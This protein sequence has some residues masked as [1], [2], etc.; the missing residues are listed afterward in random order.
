MLSGAG[1]PDLPEWLHPVLA[2]ATARDPADR[3]PSANEFR[4]ALIEPRGSNEPRPARD[5]R[6]RLAWMAA[7]GAAVALVGAAVAFLPRSTASADPMRVVVAGFENRTGDSALATIG[8][9]ASDYVARG[10][11]VTRLLHGVYDTRSSAMEAGQPL[12]IGAAAGRDL[13]SR[14][15]AGTVLWGSYYREGDSLHFEAQLIEAPTGK[16]LLSLEPAVGRVEERTRVVETL[17]QRVMAAFAVISG[18]EF[19]PWTAASVPPTYD[20]YREMLAGA[21]AAGEYDFGGAVEHYRRAAALDS[22]FSGAQSAAALWLAYGR[23]CAT[24]DSIA[25]RLEQRERLLPPIDQAQVHWATAHCERDLD[26]ELEASRAALRASPGGLGFVV[27]LLG[28]VTALESLRPQAALE[29]L[30]GFDPDRAD[31]RGR[32]LDRYANW[33]AM[34]Y[35]MLGDHRREL[36]TARSWQRGEPAPSHRS[37]D[38]AIALAALGKTREAERLAQAWLDH[39][40]PGAAFSPGEVSE[41]VALELRAHGHPEVARR[42]LD[43][44]VAWFGADGIHDAARANSFPCLWHHFSAFYYAGRWDEARAGYEALLRQDSSSVKAHAALGAL[45]VRRGDR[46]EAARMERWLEIHGRDPAASQ[47]QARIAAL[48][49]ERERAVTLLR[50]A[51]DQGQRGNLFL[52]L[53]PDFESLLDYPPYREL[54]RPKG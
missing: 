33:L 20:A 44:V 32:T 39:P 25:S 21:A 40:E 51:L 49:G 29:V 28:V 6:R 26:S 14:V 43:R 52:H 50:R 18:P 10:L 27:A 1:A 5:S 54:I 12:R 42:L 37:A 16:L 7:G 19:E 41:C 31:P 13:A 35:H 46:P 22:N 38:E 8:D 34:T 2:R 11:A 48:L 23:R 47:A 30:E 4:Q 9:I 24:V 36:A 53:D 15:E 3:F 17:R 45:A